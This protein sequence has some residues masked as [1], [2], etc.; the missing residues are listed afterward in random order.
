MVSN[1]GGPLLDCDS[2]PISIVYD[3]TTHNQVPALVGFIGGSHVAQW[4]NK[5]VRSILEI[6]L[7]T[8]IILNVLTM[9]S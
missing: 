9:V 8:I 2:G 6:F 4:D 7:N 3:A 5:T 1:G